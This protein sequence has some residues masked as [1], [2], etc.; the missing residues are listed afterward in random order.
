MRRMEVLCTYYEVEMSSSKKQIE[1]LFNELKSRPDLLKELLDTITS[2]DSAETKASGGQESS[3]LPKPKPGREAVHDVKHLCS[4]EELAKLSP[5]EVQD[6]ARRRANRPAEAFRAFRKAHFLGA[7]TELSRHKLPLGEAAIHKTPDDKFVVVYQTFSE[8]IQR[9]RLEATFSTHQDALNCIAEYKPNQSINYTIFASID[10]LKTLATEVYK[11]HETTEVL[12]RKI[13]KRL[14]FVLAYYCASMGWKK[15]DIKTARQ[16][17]EMTGNI[18]LLESKNEQSILFFDS[19]S[20]SL[21]DQLASPKRKYRGEEQH[22]VYS[23]TFAPRYKLLSRAF[24]LMHARFGIP[25]SSIFRDCLNC[26][27]SFETQGEALEEE[28]SDG[29]NFPALSLKDVKKLLEISLKRDLNLYAY[30]IMQLSTCLRNQEMSRL[31]AHKD[32]AV[33]NGSFLRYR[34]PLVKSADPDK[35]LY[36]VMKTKGKVNLYSQLTDPE[37]SLVSRFILSNMSPEFHFAHKTFFEKNGDVRNALTEPNGHQR[38]LRTTGATMLRYGLTSHVAR[39]IDPKIIMHRMGHT[40]EEMVSSVYARNLPTDANGLDPDDYLN[41][42]PLHVSGID[43]SKQ[44][45][46]WDLWLLNELLNTLKLRNQSKH[47]E[48]I[49]FIVKETTSGV[50]K[51]RSPIN[52]V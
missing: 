45:Y 37:L 22:T 11:A 30:I 52:L 28:L 50:R 42:H 18:P 20:R 49:K 8:K 31:I 9:A 15:G 33:I 24:G 7:D 51:E 17:L 26:E 48:L 36:L 2:T 6:L 44:M 14:G 13:P 5:Q 3:A 35:D 39:T 19:W 23:Q 32:K 10:D 4:A 29:T 43:I 47:L 25:Y 41:L 46:A 16:I 40:T 34:T 27:K 12:A 1:D 38:S 21:L